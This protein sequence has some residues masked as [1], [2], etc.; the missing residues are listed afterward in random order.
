VRVRLD[1]S[2][3]CQFVSLDSTAS[4][5]VLPRDATGGYWDVELGAYDLLAARFAQRGLRVTAAELQIA[6]EVEEKLDLEIQALGTRA[7]ALESQL[8]LEI[9]ENPGFELPVDT[10][11]VTGWK[12]PQTEGAT[13]NVLKEQ[14]HTG[15]A[16][17]RWGSTRQV[18]SLQ[19]NLFDTP[20]SGR[21]AVAVWLKI[22][23]VG[24]QPVLRLAVEDA[25]DGQAYYRFAQLGNG[26]VPLKSEWTQ[27]IFPVE[28]LPLEG[29]PQMRV[30]LDLMGPG[31]VW[32]D[33]VQLFHLK[34]SQNERIELSKILVTARGA[35]RNGDFADCLHML[36]GYWPQ[37][38]NRQIP[39]SAIAASRSARAETAAT[40]PAAPVS[41][42]A[43]PSPSEPGT[44]EKL[45]GYVPKFL[46]F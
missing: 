30:R 46:R 35:L 26:G 2:A 15:S 4:P 19:S 25:S 14:P 16:A 45:K 36:E 37:F 12:S 29:F 32:L 3:N 6:P 13:L 34:F 22:D 39:A 8:P 23:D 43:P 1:A 33:D 5:Q 17:L 21:L 11:G 42:D 28:D 7:A 9:L 27:Y 24:R 40:R 20:G 10:T 38:L 41:P 44:I 18:A 31:V